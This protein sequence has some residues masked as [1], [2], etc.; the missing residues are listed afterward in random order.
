M[1]GLLA[2]ETNR[3]GTNRV[4]IEKRAEPRYRCPRLVRVR[5][6][7]VPESSFKL[8]IVQNV[9]VHG[10]GLLLS[11]PVSPDTV[12][13]IEV[14]GLSTVKRFARVMHST[15][16]DGGWLVGCTLNHSLSDNELER[17]LN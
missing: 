7:T 5:T 8:A 2:P 12:L 17:L 1:S 13:E 16:Q 4:G 14:H 10:I 9:S 15:K 11:Y 3:A 6:I